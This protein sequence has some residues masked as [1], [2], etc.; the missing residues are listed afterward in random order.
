MIRAR[1]RN[2]ENAKR[3]FFYGPGITNFDLALHKVTKITESKTLGVPLRNFQHLQS[4]AVLSERLNRRKY[5]Q[6]HF[7]ARA[8][9]AY[10][11]VALLLGAITGAERQRHQRS[12]LLV[13]G[14]KS[15]QPGDCFRCTVAVANR[16][17]RSLACSL[18]IRGGRRKHAQAGTS[19]H[20]DGTEAFV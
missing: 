10:L 14:K 6:P 15:A 9:V 12:R 17:M 7:G 5:Q 19:V 3:R 2:A 1:P 4:R 13:F 8:F 20:Y 16:P 11:L 18:D